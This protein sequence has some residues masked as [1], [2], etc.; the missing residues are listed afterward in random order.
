MCSFK[1]FLLN[2]IH[3]YVL[4]VCYYYQ[5]KAAWDIPLESPSLISRCSSSRFVC[6]KSLLVI[7]TSGPHLHYAK[8]TQ[9]IVKY[10]VANTSIQLLYASSLTTYP[11]NH[12]SCFEVRFYTKSATTQDMAIW[13]IAN[14]P[15]NIITCSG[16]TYIYVLPCYY[17]PNGI[18]FAF[19]YLVLQC[20]QLLEISKALEAPNHITSFIQEYSGG[21][22]VCAM[23]NV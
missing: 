18:Q 5:S 4:Y 2:P 21:I 3:S 13:L 16:K 8:F 7:K 11:V 15:C 1:A 17:H 6:L 14:R 23:F 22:Q 12:V 9:E 10:I 20:E 19:F